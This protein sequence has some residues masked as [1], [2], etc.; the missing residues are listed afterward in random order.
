[1]TNI[2]RQVS[3]D[4]KKY[5]ESQKQGR[6]MSGNMDYCYCCKYLQVV[7]KDN[8]NCPVPQIDREL[9]CLC[10]KA[11]NKMKKKK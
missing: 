3:L 10:A 11:F 9:K 4:E 7:D 1:M 5:F 2:E 6:D 8:Y